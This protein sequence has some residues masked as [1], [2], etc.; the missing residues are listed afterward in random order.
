MPSVTVTVTVTARIEGSVSGTAFASDL[1]TN[2]LKDNPLCAASL[3]DQMPHPLLVQ[4]S[5]HPRLPLPNK[6]QQALR[7][8]TLPCTRNR[9]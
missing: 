4:L 5:Q 8:P 3:P 6:L 1:A 9:C 7:D 2:L